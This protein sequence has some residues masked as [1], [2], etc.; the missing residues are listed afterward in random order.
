MP[1]IVSD[2][3]A[4]PYGGIARDIYVNREQFARFWRCSVEC[5]DDLPVNMKIFDAMEVG[6]EATGYKLLNHREGAL[7]YL[8]T[9]IDYRR[10]RGYAQS[11]SN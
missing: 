5:V 3:Y 6:G 8:I 9:I 10:N 7:Q 1:T 2:H 11:L 4:H